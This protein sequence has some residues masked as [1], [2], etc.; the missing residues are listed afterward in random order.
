M[1]DDG[2]DPIAKVAADADYLCIGDEFA[3]RVAGHRVAQPAQDRS[4]YCGYVTADYSGKCYCEFAAGASVNLPTASRALSALKGARCRQGRRADK[5][6]VPP[7]MPLSAAH[8][9]A[10][11]C[12]ES[13]A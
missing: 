5:S 7:E 10:I 3:L 2:T 12:V 13:A 6:T 8:C 1:G 4:V 9:A 11:R